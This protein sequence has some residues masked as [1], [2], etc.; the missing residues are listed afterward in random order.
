M[1]GYCQKDDEGQAHYQSRRLNVTDQELADGKA[2]YA[3]VRS[4]YLKERTTILKTNIMVL[5]YNFYCNEIGATEEGQ[6]ARW[7]GMCYATA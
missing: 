6:L 5:V 2:A 1:L 3:A 7:T 4:R